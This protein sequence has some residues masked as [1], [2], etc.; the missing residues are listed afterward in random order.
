MSSQLTRCHAENRRSLKQV[1][2]YL[3]SLDKRLGARMETGMKGVHRRWKGVHASTD[4]YET[5]LN[6]VRSEDLVYL[7]ADS[8]NV[9]QSLER[10]KV[11]IIG[12]LVDRNRHK[13]QTTKIT[14]K[15]NYRAFVMK[16]L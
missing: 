3:T 15:V 7:T 5:A 12:G 13:V 8:P 14:T 4:S 11:Y 1:E 9:I 16:K 10:D 2:I 6:D